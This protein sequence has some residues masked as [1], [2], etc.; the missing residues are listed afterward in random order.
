MNQ[1]LFRQQ[2]VQHQ[3]RGLQGDILL[4]SSLPALM[5]SGA[6]LV[7][8]IAMAIWLSASEYARKETVSGWLEPPQGVLRVYANNSGFIKELLVHEG[9]TVNADQPL[10]IIHGNNLLANG[11]GMEGQLLQELEHQQNLLLEQQQRNQQ[12]F[13]QREAEGLQR[14]SR[15]R[16]ELHLLEQQAITLNS[17]QQLLDK[18]RER[19]QRLLSSGHISATDVEQSQFEVLALKAEQQTLARQTLQQ[20]RLL[21]DAQSEQEQLPQNHADQQTLLATQ[22]S[23]LNQQIT[24]WKNR[25]AYVI[26]A[27]RAG[28]VSN[29]R[30]RV[31][32]QVTASQQTPL[33]TLQPAQTA[34]T[35]QL[36]LPARAIGFVETGQQ[37][38][39][40]FDAFPYQKFGIHS[41]HITQLS[42][43]VLLPGELQQIPVSVKE[44]VYL[45]VAQLDNA[46]VQAYGRNFSL[47]SGMTLSADIRLEERSLLRWLFEPLYSLRGRL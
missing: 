30:A 8:F 44:P 17:R 46:Q 38:D 7:W 36:L 3:H 28:I 32:Q 39:I 43:T 2:A 5:V 10:L 47:K 16:E 12:R 24:Q 45:I 23:E 37:L 31:G 25:Q 26:K 29:L 20:H 33:L 14:I 41:A 11:D 1:P 15:V 18:Q 35:V 21:E 42:D 4:T 9:E 6:L 34:L 19:Q 13:A 27:T 22:I 40:R